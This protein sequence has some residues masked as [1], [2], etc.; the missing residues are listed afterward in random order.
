MSSK[1]EIWTDNKTED[2]GDMFGIFFEDLNHAADGGLYAELIQNRSFEFSPIDNRNYH[3]FTAWEK[4]S[5]ENAVF[6][7]ED[8][9]PVNQKN[10]HYFV[11]D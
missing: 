1:W 6:S 8:T 4:I 3:F 7:I 11:M 5:E 9:N 10:P 2:M